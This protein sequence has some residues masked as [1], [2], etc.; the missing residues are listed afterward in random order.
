MKN[1]QP[2]ERDKARRKGYDEDKET[3]KRQSMGRSERR[4][5]KRQLHSDKMNGFQFYVEKMKHSLA[6]IRKKREG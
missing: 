1:G 3:R 4:R 2:R 6:A 5:D